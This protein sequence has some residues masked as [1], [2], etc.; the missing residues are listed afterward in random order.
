MIRVAIVEDIQEIREGISYLINTAEGFECLLQFENAEDA[1]KALSDSPVDVVLMDI[2]LPGMSGIE[3]VEKLKAQHPS[4]QFL[5]CTVYE[6]DDFVFDAL[7]KGATGYLLKKTPA[8]KI[9]EAIEE[10][11]NGGSP[12]SASIARRVIESFRKSS[13]NPWLELL[14]QRERELLELL[15]KGFRYK[16]I[17]AQLFLSTETVRTHIRNI[18]QKLQVQSRT[19][20]LNK[21]Y[22]RS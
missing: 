3:C 5:M 21:I 16:E 2:H 6:D 9:I 11:H 22:G 12:M 18:Y 15:S 20:A 1:L 10:I 14:T 8:A 17:A 19:E 7:Q 4:M 13:S